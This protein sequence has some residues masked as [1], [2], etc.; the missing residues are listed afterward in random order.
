MK[1]SGVDDKDFR[2]GNDAPYDASL[3]GLPLTPRSQS[4]RRGWRAW[5]VSQHDTKI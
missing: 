2:S 1:S 4:S 3:V 5:V